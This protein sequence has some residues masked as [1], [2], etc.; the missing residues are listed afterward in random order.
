MVELKVQPSAVH[1]HAKH[2]A[3]VILTGISSKLYAAQYFPTQQKDTC[4]RAWAGH[5]EINS[6]L[7]D[8][9]KKK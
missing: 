2:S 1:I 8:S 7:I 4:Y 5:S 9:L 3:N 6:L